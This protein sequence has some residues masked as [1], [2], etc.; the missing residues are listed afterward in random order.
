MKID[1]K[2]TG[3]CLC[4]GV[5]FKLDK[6]ISGFSTCHCDMCRR[7]ASGPYFATNCGKQVRF[8]GEENIGRFKSSKWAERGFCKICGSSLFYYLVPTGHY[9][10]SVGT[11]DDQNGI[12]MKLQVFI[13]EKPDCYDF[14]SESRRM[15]GEQVFAKYVPK[16]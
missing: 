16:E 2:K 8:D 7:W 14:T 5:T 4:G 12:D 10:M 13:D 1:G 11:F 6:S 3:S 15:T 9:M